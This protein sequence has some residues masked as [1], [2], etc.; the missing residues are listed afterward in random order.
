LPVFRLRRKKIPIRKIEK[1]G[2]GM[3]RNGTCTLL[4]LVGVFSLFLVSVHEAK[5]EFP[6]R[7]ITLINTQ[8]PGGANDALA[9]PFAAVAEKYLGKPI[10]VVNKPGASGM[11]GNIAGAEAAP[12]GYTLTIGSTLMTIVMDWEKVNGRKPAASRNDY[13]TVGV[14][15]VIPTVL[16]VPYGSPWKTLSDLVNGVKAKPGQYT[17]CSA[18][19]LSPTHLGSERFVRAYGLNV[20]HVPYKGGGPALTALVGGHADFTTQFSLTSIPLAR[21]NKLRILA[22]Q[23]QQRVKS[24]PE[25]PTMKEA[26]MDVENGMWLGIVAP[27]KTPAPIVQKL[28]EVTAKVVKD[29]VYIEAVR[30]L[31]EEVRSMDGSEL[32][33]YWDQESVDISKLLTQLAKEGLKINP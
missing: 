1:G 4:V 29:P 18:G 5:A 9:R 20:R 33:K 14:L 22:V 6:E 30:A 10:V 25:V 8:A 7:P 31:G 24:I 26:G 13:E 27:R 23:S 11:I 12:D 32:A 19:L 3:K 28:R 15:S 21:G 16:S 2:R 17:F